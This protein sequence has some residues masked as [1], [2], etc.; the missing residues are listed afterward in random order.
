MV[1]H[2]RA[3]GVY[4]CACMCVTGKSNDAAMQHYSE[5]KEFLKIYATTCKLWY[6]Q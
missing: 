3:H 5:I 2:V 4:V 6:I 1:C